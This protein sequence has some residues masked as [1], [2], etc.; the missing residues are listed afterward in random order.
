M[1]NEGFVYGVFRSLITW[2]GM[3]IVCG[4]T[5]SLS[6]TLGPVKPSFSVP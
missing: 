2:F 5:M 3:L 6:R 4:G 1:K